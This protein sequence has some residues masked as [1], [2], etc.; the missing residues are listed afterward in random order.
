V[1]WEDLTLQ[2]ATAG[3]RKVVTPFQSPFQ[4]ISTEKRVDSILIII[5]RLL[6]FGDDFGYT[7]W[8]YGEI[9]GILLIVLLVYLLVGRGRF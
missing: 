4:K 1:H 6:I 5:A 9:S 2:G 7:R 8:G 3:R